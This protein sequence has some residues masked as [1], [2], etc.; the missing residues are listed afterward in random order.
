MIP[1]WGSL[2]KLHGEMSP[3][4]EPV[5]WVLRV[6]FTKV[7]AAHCLRDFRSWQ[8]EAAGWKCHS[9]IMER[10]S[11]L[12]D[13][14]CSFTGAVLLEFS[15]EAVAITWKRVKTRRRGQW[16]REREREHKVYCIAVHTALFI[17]RAEGNVFCPCGGPSRSEVVH[18]HPSFGFERSSESACS[19]RWPCLCGFPPRPGSLPPF[20]FRQCLWTLLSRAPNIYTGCWCLF[21]KVGRARGRGA[22]A[23]CAERTPETKHPLRGIVMTARPPCLAPWLLSDTSTFLFRT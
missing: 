20:I 18:L 10:F 11:L 6:A 2:R 15:H 8:R 19:Q 16:K 17:P 23:Q 21:K 7:S 4:G 9:S 13:T 12:L 14:T 1:R 3:G 5:C 22:E